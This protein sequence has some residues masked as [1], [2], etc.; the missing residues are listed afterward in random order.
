[1]SLLSFS[2]TL[3]KQDF[4]GTVEKVV[5]D[6]TR[7]GSTYSYDSVADAELTLADTEVVFSTDN[8]PVTGTLDLAA[9]FHFPNGGSSCAKTI[10]L[11][12]VKSDLYPMF[13]GSIEYAESI[14]S[15][16]NSATYVNH[17]APTTTTKAQRLIDPNLRNTLQPYVAGA[18]IS[19]QGTSYGSFGY[20]Q[21]II[22]RK[23]TRSIL[24]QTVGGR[25]YIT[26][27]YAGSYDTAFTTTGNFPYPFGP[28]G[29]NWFAYPARYGTFT[30]WQD[31]AIVNGTVT[32]APA[33]GAGFSPAFP[34][35][36]TPLGG[37]ISGSFSAGNLNQLYAAPQRHNITDTFNH[38]WLDTDRGGSNFYQ[39]AP[40]FGSEP[41]DFY[42]P[43]SVGMFNYGLMFFK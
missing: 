22:N 5:L 9:T 20:L 39:I 25:E 1:M 2:F 17:F 24:G 27:P 3:N 32:S 18:P 31:A 29:M 11:S 6:F 16:V 8:F 33:R 15:R 43:N 40:L 23:T 38:N 30:S 42:F 21:S 19:W 7:L 34:A 14:N 10:S 36:T 12:Q 35:N 37:T 26:I 41:Y 13:Y 4:S 28:V